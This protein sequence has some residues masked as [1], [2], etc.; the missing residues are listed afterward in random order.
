MRATQSYTQLTFLC[1]K[2][3]TLL[4]LLSYGVFERARCARAVHV[5][6][7]LRRTFLVRPDCATFVLCTRA[8]LSL[9]LLF[10]ADDDYKQKPSKCRFCVGIKWYACYVNSFGHCSLQPVFKIT[11]L[12]MRIY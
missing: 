7:G 5:S 10:I 1:D 11:L 12:S 6:I 4:P 2:F 9:A 8:P 3:S